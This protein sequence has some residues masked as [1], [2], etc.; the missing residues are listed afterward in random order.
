M[1]RSLLII[2]LMLVIFMLPAA[3]IYGTENDSSSAQPPAQDEIYVTAKV[4]KVFD[5]EDK[6]SGVDSPFQEQIVKVK[7]LSGEYEGEIIQAHNSLSGSKGLDLNI[8]PGDKVVLY[9]TEDQD[10]ITEAY[11]ADMA[12]TSYLGYLVGLF[13]L[14]LIIIGGMAGIKSIVALGLT[15]LGVYKVLLPALLQGYSPLPITVVILLVITML[16][17]FIVAGISKKSIAATLGTMGGVLAA[18]LIALIIGDTAS[19]TG[20]A[21]EESRMLLYVENLKIDMQGLLFAG[22]I[23]GALGA[24]MDVAI[25]IASSIEEVKKAN[26]SLKPGDLFRA[27][28]NVGR[29]IMGTMTNTLILAYTGGALPLLILFMAYNTSAVR[30][31]NSELIA[32]EIVRALVGS[33]G[34]VFSVPITAMFAAM[35]AGKTTKFYLDNDN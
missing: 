4:L 7:I 8:K 28:L 27:G 24:T 35:L 5:L 15:I 23:I 6:Q 13:I 11:I 3:T 31:F 34:L 17:M 20:F 2:I 21:D 18:G 29:D 19:L 22:I 16:T 9:L 1:R 12:R 33:I 30:I 26:P 10:K 32:T 25:S 14:G